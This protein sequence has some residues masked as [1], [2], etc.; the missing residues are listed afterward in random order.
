MRDV[1]PDEVT[2]LAAATRSHDPAVGLTA[3]AAM[4]S[5]VDVLEALQVDNARA[6]GWTWPAIAERLAVSKQAVHQK[7]ARR[8]RSR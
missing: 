8:R 7:Y 4:R 2:T 6:E 1:L 3:V 5:L